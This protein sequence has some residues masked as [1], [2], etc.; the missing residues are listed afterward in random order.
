MVQDADSEFLVQATTTPGNVSDGA[1][2]PQVARPQA[3][4]MTGDKA[5]DSKTNQTHLVDLGVGC[6]L[7]PRR[8]RP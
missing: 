3:Q 1:V 6:G 2:L 4:E 8:P 5:Y 7:I